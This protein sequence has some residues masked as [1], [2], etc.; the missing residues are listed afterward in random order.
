ME[1]YFDNKIAV[2]TG[3]SWGIGRR[4]CEMFLDD[5]A[6]VY[7]C[8]I[9]PEGLDVIEQKGARTKVI[10]LLD[11]G[12]TQQWVAD[13]EKQCD[14]PIDILI[15]NAGGF[16]D[17]EPRFIEDVTDHEWDTVMAINPTITFNQSRAVV[18]GMKRAGRGRIINM[19]SGA[20]I[21]ASRTRIHPYTAA[22][23][24]VVGLTRQMAHEL[25]QFGITVN[26]VAPG[27]V[28]SSPFT[29]A[30]WA[31][32]SPEAQ[33]AHVQGTFMRRVGKPDDIANTVMF[34]A[35]DRAEWITGQVLSVDGGR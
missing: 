30:D 18:P 32:Y 21:G 7:G 28:I 2:V 27:F 24:A 1:I 4:I 19:S 8:D 22:K 31:K 17:A 14:R 3:A 9:R 29:E 25:G 20:G 26:S 16:A 12:A 33:N 23:H 11:R 6:I 34:L 5:G 15:N 13:I 10:D 35:S